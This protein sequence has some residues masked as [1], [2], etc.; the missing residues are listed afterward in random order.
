MHEKESPGNFC[1]FSCSGCAFFACT[2]RMEWDILTGVPYGGKRRLRSRLPFRCYRLLLKQSQTMKL[3]L[4]NGLRRA[5]LA[6]LAALAL[7]VTSLP[8]TLAT[9][10]GFTAA[11]IMATQ[12][13]AAAAEDE[14]PPEEEET[15]ESRYP[16]ITSTEDYRAAAC[17]P[18][19][20]KNTETWNI[21]VDSSVDG[22]S[23]WFQGKSG[24]SPDAAAA[25]WNSVTNANLN[26]LRTLT[27]G[28]N[29]SSDKTQTFNGN[30]T[31]GTNVHL[32]FAWAGHANTWQFNGKLGGF[33]G[34]IQCT[35]G[36]INVIFG[37]DQN[38]TNWQTNTGAITQAG[39]TLNLTLY[40]T[41][42]KNENGQHQ[43][44]GVG[45][46][47]VSVN[48]LT[49]N[50]GVEF[51][52]GKVTAAGALTL[53]G[54]AYLSLQGVT[55]EAKT[56]VLGGDATVRLHGG[57]N[58]FQI[59][60]GTFTS[61]DHTL[62]IEL[63]DVLSD[64]DIGLFGSEHYGYDLFGAE[65]AGLGGHAKLSAHSESGRALTFNDAG[66]VV[67]ADTCPTLRWEATVSER[68]INWT[69]QGAWD[70]ATYGYPPPDVFFEGVG[71][72]VYVDAKAVDVV[73]ANIG[74]KG[75]EFDFE[76]TGKN[77]PEGTLT[78]HGTVF[79]E[80]G[81]TLRVGQDLTVSV[82][83]YTG[84]G[85][86]KMDGGTFEIREIEEAANTV[87]GSLSVTEKGGTLRLG[88]EGGAGQRITLGVVGGPDGEAV[89]ELRVEGVGGGV[90]VNFSDGGELK[91][92]SQ[93][94]SG[95]VSVGVG[96]DLSLVEGGS[97]GGELSFVGGDSR[98]HELKIGGDL[99]VGGG[100]SSSSS[101]EGVDFYKIT[102]TS[103]EEE[104]VTLTIGGEKDSGE[105]VVT[106]DITIGG[107]NVGVNLVKQGGGI[108]VFKGEEIDIWGDVT[109][110]SGVLRIEGATGEEKGAEIHGALSGDG[111][112]AL[113]SSTVVLRGASAQIGQLRL[114]GEGSVL[115]LTK[116]LVVGDIM[117][118]STGTIQR[119]KEGAASGT[120]LYVLFDPGNELWTM[121]TFLGLV[122]S[123]VTLED[124]AIGIG[125]G[126]EGETRLQ[127]GSG[128]PVEDFKLAGSG[129]LTWVEGEQK[130]WNF[131]GE[132]VET[133]S[134]DGTGTE[135]TELV[136]PT[137]KVKGG[138]LILGKNPEL[139]D[140]DDPEDPDN[141]ERRG[142]VSGTLKAV[143]M[144]GARETGRAILTLR[145]GTLQAHTLIG[146]PG[147]VIE[148]ALGSAPNHRGWLD[149]AE[150]TTVDG[151]FV[152]RLTGG[153]GEKAGSVQLFANDVQWSE[154]LKE[155]LVGEGGTG[156]AWADFFRIEMDKEL[157][158]EW[159]VLDAS[160]LRFRITGTGV[161]EIANVDYLD[162]TGSEEDV[163]SGKETEGWGNGLSTPELKDLR[164]TEGLGSDVVNIGGGVSPKNVDIESGVFTFQQASGSTAG[165]LNMSGDEKGNGVLHIHEDAVL[166]L[167]LQ[168][169]SIPM[170]NLEGTL[171]LGHTGAL[172]EG[173]H[174]QFNGGML[175]YDTN[176]VA[177]D[178]SEL[179]DGDSAGPVKVAVDGVVEGGVTWGSS[180]TAIGDNRGLNIA[181]NGKGLEKSDGDGNFTLAWLDEGGEHKADLA[182]AKG[183]LTLD[184]GGTDFANMSGD[185]TGA[186]TLVV[187]GSSKVTLSG[188]NTVQ[189]IVLGQ[190]TS[191][192]LK[193]KTALG[194]A[195]TVL[196]LAGGTLT[197]DN[198]A[199]A[200]AGTVKVDADTTVSV[201]TLTGAVSGSGALSVEDGQ[202]AGLAGD[203]SGYKGELRTGTSGTWRLSGGALGKEVGAAVSGSGTVQFDGGGTF[204]G[205][206]RGGVTLRGNNGE[207]TVVTK[208]SE[209]VRATLAGTVALGNASKQAEWWD[210][211]VADG[212][213]IY[214]S[215]VDLHAQPTKGTGTKLYVRTATSKTRPENGITVNVN[216]MVDAGSLDGI[217][218]NGHGQLQGIT[219]RYTVNG[220]HGLELHFARENVEDGGVS[221]GTAGPAASLLAAS[222][223]AKALIVGEEVVEGQVGFTLES[224]DDTGR[225]IWLDS[226]AVSEILTIMA[227]AKEEEQK[228]TA[229]LHVVEQGTLTMGGLTLDDLLG[230]EVQ[231]LRSLD[232]EFEVDEANGNL[233]LKGSAADVFVAFAGKSELDNGTFLDQAKATVLSDET[234]DFTL[235]LDGATHAGNEPDVTVHNL[236]GLTG[237]MLHLQNS[238]ADTGANRLTVA[239]DNTQV[240]KIKDPSKYPTVEDTTVYGQ[241]T[242]YNGSIDA[243]NG[244]DVTK[245]GYGTLTVGGTYMLADGT[246]TIRE[247]ALRLRGESNAMEG[248]TFDYTEDAQQTGLGEEYRGLLLEDGTTTV[249]GAISDEGEVG[250]GDIKL[251][252]AELILNGQSTLEG[253]SITSEDGTGKL[254]LKKA[255]GAA[256]GTPDPSLT[257]SG[258]KVRAVLSGVDVDVQAGLLKLQKGAT[259]TGGSAKIGDT[260]TLDLGDSAGHELSSLEGS[261]VLKSAFGGKVRVGGDSSFSGK[262]GSSE[263]G[264]KAGTLEV[265]AGANFTLS[266][267][268]TTATNTANGWGIT[269]EGSKQDG[270]PGG[271]LTID[272]SGKAAGEQLTLG[273]VSLGSGSTTTIKLNAETYDAGEKTTIVG[274]SLNFG[275]DASI[276]LATEGEAWDY[277]RDLTLGTYG[278]VGGDLED[279]KDRIT[280]DGVGFFQKEVEEVVVE[281]GKVTVKFTASAGIELNGAGGKNANAGATL[282]NGS[283]KNGSKQHAMNSDTDYARVM[284]YFIANR[285][286]PTSIENPLSAFAGA[287]VS[288]LGPALSED[289]HRQL[290]SIRNRTTTMANEVTQE[291]AG[292]LPLWHAWINAEGNYH[293][294]DAD[295]LAPGY[296]LNSWG[297]TVGADAD[298]TPHVTVGLA[299]TAMYG[300]LDA[301][302]P[303][304]ATGDMDTSYLSAFVRATR[305]AWIHTFVVSGGIANVKLNR[306]VNF[307]GDSYTT[308]GD[309][310]GYAFGA[311]YEVGYTGL[312]NKRG[313]AA[314]QPVFNVEVRHVAISGYA[315]TG[316]DAGVDVDDID[317]TVV[318]FGAGVRAQ[319]AVATNAFNRTSV[320]ESRLLLK[321]DVGDRSGTA[322]N[323][324]VGD[325]TRAEV[326]SAEV[327][328]VGVEFGAGISVPLGSDLGSVFLDGSVEYRE[329]WT[330][331][332]ATLGYRMTF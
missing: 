218:I 296:T 128:T 237:S 8:T 15:P 51:T 19:K 323:A 176:G 121:D 305:G 270:T 141:P 109:I 314:L 37:S 288:I 130:I 132:M 318:T 103:T 13:V 266:N 97:V 261:G 181:L 277:T 148:L 249:R 157:L 126:G 177:P 317:R 169:T 216:G 125:K 236:L 271:N 240:D 94:G 116:D 304:T 54:G 119:A 20:N 238:N 285:K 153:G 7:P 247:G 250:K 138:R 118:D 161:L 92:L 179:V 158:D 267:V 202:S 16:K 71:G 127:A 140:P 322:S 213:T 257:L 9:A 211:A 73:H 163:W 280:L 224:K 229:I 274:S 332:N 129:T 110:E 183:T 134:E 219:G 232:T 231:I 298:L 312:V 83:S 241:H 35:A 226:D 235:N 115:E 243:G 275:E 188:N 98:N 25:D 242:T 245:V 142:E 207:L 253:T 82:G 180:D 95:S 137:L 33:S 159:G 208:E 191:T 27:V 246:T 311:M 4:P 22:Y 46:S 106:G 29:G 325:K 60:G 329:G 156:Y 252:N 143:D 93:V 306:T 28:N 189:G 175:L 309:T 21:D 160:E 265:V 281:D 167:N 326:E 99:T 3:H 5:L 69:A 76:Y 24:D 248:L 286:N 165:G 12:Q 190:G 204:G 124:G 168:N 220:A 166:H 259:M 90:S 292:E 310:D 11:C 223:E 120:R 34:N 255:E 111:R 6:C 55:L 234:T 221:G 86:L 199:E 182:V 201:V 122:P 263:E 135:E 149:F 107:K 144:S 88:E 282:V 100:L 23:F 287:S 150:I 91:R 102:S 203:L 14:T 193:G 74:G 228:A 174:L 279:L 151:P 172:P 212:S 276:V 321:L 260:G 284:K 324:I 61:N 262:L 79:V 184:V 303:D 214:L 230:D 104:A 162:W 210:T 178:V 299:I 244:V 112:L 200:Q 113:T 57:T 66:K 330:S 294:M 192:Y 291:A 186:G 26:F 196:T 290:G 17:D 225:K 227:Q 146:A 105:T 155:L 42:D 52:R 302:A 32:V 209:A 307:G 38:R 331:A 72:T 320:L 45:S 75:G 44:S 84:N 80:E 272:V 48:N 62:T 152:I 278:S 41:N 47:G 171:G 68:A 89:G 313:T 49:V 117:D 164:F 327:G 297:G 319:A 239:F 233:V 31:G 256:E 53:A 205:D 295:S 217:T 78:V 87:I 67:Y 301:D 154:S 43:V 197:G 39:G 147:A 123:G 50:G 65:I 185:I 58:L 145:A 206:V 85:T 40:G 283:Y 198:G 101:G 63:D 18:E 328:E 194:G 114:S 136:G 195:E 2:L 251:S 77:A 131:K 222:G 108:Q 139:E 269:V 308:H 254:T 170:V 56:I 1:K 289:L 64:T 81:N 96:G 70:G 273:A 315:E 268:T 187:G 59:T 30:F 264:G 293:K 133:E 316:S 258:E 215:N 10:S 36:T 173:T 300:D